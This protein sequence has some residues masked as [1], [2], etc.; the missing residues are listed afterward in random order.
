MSKGPL[1]VARTSARHAVTY[2][3]RLSQDKKTFVLVIESTAKMSWLE[4][5]RHAIA[6][7]KDEQTRVINEAGMSEEE[8]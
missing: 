6:W 4:A 7:G 5:V 8:H 2:D 1:K 3:P